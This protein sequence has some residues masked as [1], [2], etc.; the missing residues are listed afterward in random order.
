VTVRELYDRLRSEVGD[1]PDAE[2]RIVVHGWTMP[3]LNLA[4]N[5]VSGG[6]IYPLNI[7]AD[8]PRKP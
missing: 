7:L 4:A 3:S 1:N 2:V 6:G 5:G 8:E